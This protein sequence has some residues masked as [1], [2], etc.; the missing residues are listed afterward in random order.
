MACII[1]NI[2]LCVSL[3]N[4]IPIKYNYVTFFFY[5]YLY[6]STILYVHRTGSVAA[7]EI[8]LELWPG[9]ECNEFDVS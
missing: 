1:C 6:M 4:R 9:E 2:L 3:K 5:S 8:D 7:F